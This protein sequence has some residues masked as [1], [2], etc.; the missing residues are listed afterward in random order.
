MKIWGIVV[1]DCSKKGIKRLIDKYSHEFRKPENLNYYS[2]QD[3]E[4]AERCFVKFR[5]QHG[6]CQEAKEHKDKL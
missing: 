3:F 6:S 1:A 2:S 4:R 5:L